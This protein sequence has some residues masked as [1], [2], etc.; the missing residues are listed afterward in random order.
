MGKNMFWAPKEYLPSR[1]LM[2][3]YGVN[4]LLPIGIRDTDSVFRM[5]RGFP[6]SVKQ[7]ENFIVCVWNNMMASLQQQQRWWCWQYIAAICLV[8][9]DTQHTVWVAN[10]HQCFNTFC[11]SQ[12][13]IL[14]SSILQVRKRAKDFIQ[15]HTS[16]S[17]F[18]LQ[19]PGYWS[20]WKEENVSCQKWFIV[21]VLANTFFVH[22]RF[23]YTLCN[24]L[25]KYLKCHSHIQHLTSP[26]NITILP[27]S[28]SYWINKQ[29][30][31]LPT[32]QK[33]SSGSISTP[34]KT[35]FL[36]SQHLMLMIQ[37]DVRV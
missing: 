22:I 1:A 10:V 26:G 5:L 25:I 18:L 6:D 32:K 12:K 35:F 17:L 33:H 30:A 19:M 36:M 16:S 13:K 34:Y 14:L 20:L 21:K 37:R 7:W 24:S 9:R 15:N 4:C 31:K 28:R 29:V 2:P 23:M 27:G 8:L 11:H 3:R